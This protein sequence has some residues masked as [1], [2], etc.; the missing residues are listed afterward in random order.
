MYELIKK[1]FLDR[2]K[3]VE[4]FDLKDYPIEL[5]KDKEVILTL[6]KINGLFL[7][8]ASDNVA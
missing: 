6:V 4:H 5:K 3:G 7:Q 8:Y 1:D 2:L